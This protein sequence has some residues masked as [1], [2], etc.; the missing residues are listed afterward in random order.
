MQTDTPKASC[1]ELGQIA[2]PVA[3][4]QGHLFHQRLTRFWQA[5]ARNFTIHDEPK[6]WQSKS[7]LGHS[8]WNVYLPKTGEIVRLGSEQEV[9]IWLEE[10]LR[11]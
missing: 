1:W 6:V 5:I 2:K 9:R 8:G 3:N 11:F 4:L 10:H 7:W